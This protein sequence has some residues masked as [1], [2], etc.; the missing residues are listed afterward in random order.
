M[1]YKLRWSDES[2]RNLGEILDYLRIHWTEKEVA[3][4]SEKLSHQL[5][6]ILKNP[7]MFPISAYAPKLRK[8]VLS[9]QTTI[10]YKIVENTVYLAYL[11][12]IRKDIHRIK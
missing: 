10:F 5:N 12:L 4:F 1:D 9:K 7:N 6:L 11:H 8:A 2:V 3:S